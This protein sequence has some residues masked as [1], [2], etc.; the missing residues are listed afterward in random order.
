MMTWG[1]RLCC[2]RFC[3]EILIC[4]DHVRVI[5]IE[6]AS[7]GLVSSITPGTN[8]FWGSL[9]ALRASHIFSLI[10]IFAYISVWS[11]RPYSFSSDLV[12]HILLA[13]SFLCGLPPNLALLAQVLFSWTSWNFLCSSEVAITQV[14]PTKPSTAGT[15]IW[16]DSLT[17]SNGGVHRTNRSMMTRSFQF[18]RFF[19]CTYSYYAI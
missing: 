5:E 6:T 10:R 1:C 12:N 13:A 7:S 16:G 11:C 4:W 19:C 18:F 9:C 15:F 2:L 14:Y 3:F 8:R 17:F